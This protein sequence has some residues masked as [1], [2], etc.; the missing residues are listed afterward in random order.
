MFMRKLFIFLVVLFVGLFC[1]YEFMT[2]DRNYTWSKEFEDEVKAVA[3]VHALHVAKSVEINVDSVKLPTERAVKIAIQRTLSNIH[4]MNYGR[5][6]GKAIVLIPDS[7][8]ALLICK[9]W[10]L[11]DHIMGL[12]FEYENMDETALTSLK[13]DFNRHFSNYKI[14]WTPL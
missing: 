8:N 9:A 5:A 10:C 1:F 13:N 14:V 4:L 2:Y 12:E 11:S 6:Y 3:T 7:S